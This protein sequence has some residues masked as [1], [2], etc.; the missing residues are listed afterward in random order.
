MARHKNLTSDHFRQFQIL[1]LANNVLQIRKG[2][3]KRTC[4]QIRG[5]ISKNSR[6]QIKEFIRIQIT[7]IRLK[8][9]KLAQENIIKLSYKTNKTSK[10]TTL[11]P[12]FSL[13]GFYLLHQSYVIPIKLVFV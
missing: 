1:L 4:Q 5:R 13:D 9:T 3:A 6:F 8:I 2:N 11:H 7:S 12:S 10:F